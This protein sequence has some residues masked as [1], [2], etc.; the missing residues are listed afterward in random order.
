M[1]P[2]LN[3]A[4]TAA[5]AA[6]QIITRASMNLDQV[7]ISQK[8]VQDLVTEIDHAA[9]D[10]IKSI[11]LEAYPKHAFLGEE[12]GLTGHVNSNHKWIVDPIDGT[13]NFIHGYPH[14]AVCIALEIDG[15]VE[16]GLIYNPCTNDLFTA[17]R[18]SG[19]FLN[20]RRIRVSGRIRLSDALLSTAIP[21]K[22][23]KINP[24]LVGLQTS[25]RFNASGLRYSGSSALDLAYVAAGHIDGFIGV[26]L[27]PWDI[28]AGALL[29]KE[30]GGL[31]TD[32]TGEGDFMSGSI[33]AAAPKILPHL[34][35]EINPAE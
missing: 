29:V 31:I 9:E 28:A 6:A 30:A 18:G 5:R 8:G 13:N 14:Y 17:S 25:L 24:S 22:E 4:V 33:V 20:N 23:L 16:H 1:H 19:A 7:K 2:M 11:L 10:A 32:L 3:T 27:S 21:S 35:R 12:S 15:K 26:G 34:L